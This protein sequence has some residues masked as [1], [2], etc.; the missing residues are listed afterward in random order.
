MKWFAL[1]TL[2]VLSAAV[3]GGSNAQE[4]E[5]TGTIAFTRAPGQVWMMSAD[6][7]RQRALTR[8]GAPVWSPD[9][10]RVA[11]ILRGPNYG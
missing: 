5:T 7:S 9:G 10:R 11:Y 1:L 3:C 4:P 8:G 6:G 2:I